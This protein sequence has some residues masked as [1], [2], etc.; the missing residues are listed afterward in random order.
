MVW[1]INLASLGLYLI[2]VAV[3]S[4]ALQRGFS[5]GQK[6]LGMIIDSQAFF[7]LTDHGCNSSITMI[8]VQI[9]VLYFTL[10]FRAFSCAYE[11]RRTATSRLGAALCSFLYYGPCALL[12]PLLPCNALQQHANRY[13][14]PLHFA[15]FHYI[16]LMFS[17]C[18]GELRA[19]GETWGKDTALSQSSCGCVTNGT[20]IS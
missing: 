11:R 15:Y 1:W 10:S 6:R 18:E 7:A 17:D 4:I 14:I 20:P 3:A 12:P 5:L 9:H 16:D 19:E 8:H 2:M 13:Q